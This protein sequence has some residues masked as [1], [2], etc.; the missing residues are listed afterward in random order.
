MYLFFYLHLIMS[1]LEEACGF[2]PS[3]CTCIYHGR[4]DGTGTRYAFDYLLYKAK[5]L[6]TLEITF[7]CTLQVTD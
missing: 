3:Q 1:F 6:R 7:S 5:G 2:C 4:S